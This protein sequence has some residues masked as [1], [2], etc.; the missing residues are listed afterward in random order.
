[1]VQSTA[2]E[3]SMARK[4]I[5][6]LGPLTVLTRNRVTNRPK[7]WGFV[8]MQAGANGLSLEYDTY[9]DAVAA[10]RQLLVGANAYQVPSVKLLGAIQ[11]A[12]EQAKKDALDVPVLSCNKEAGTWKQGQESSDK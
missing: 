4:P 2:H 5:T 8:V 9:E 11:Q 12:M 6:F 7:T 1:M 3:E 10:R